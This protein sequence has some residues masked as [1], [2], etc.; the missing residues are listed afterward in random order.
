LDFFFF[1]QLFD[2]SLGGGGL[3]K[4]VIIMVILKFSVIFYLTSQNL[5]IIFC[6]R[7]RKN[8]SLADFI[9]AFKTGQLLMM[10]LER[11]LDYCLIKLY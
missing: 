5:K 10:K 7:Q 11:M 6:F 3:K 4:I 1:C 9:L 8:I 2:Q